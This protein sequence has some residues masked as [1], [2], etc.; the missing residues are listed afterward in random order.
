MNAIAFR[1]EDTDKIVIRRGINRELM[2]KIVFKDIKERNK[3]K[4]K[5]G[6]RLEFKINILLI[7]TLLL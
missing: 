4:F 2:N 1:G 5:R 3:N 7:R 6:K